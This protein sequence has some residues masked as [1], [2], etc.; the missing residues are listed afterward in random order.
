MKKAIFTLAAVT[1][2]VFW[3]SGCGATFDPSSKINRFRILSVEI[4]KS[5][6]EFG[7]EINLSAL[8]VNE[9]GSVAKSAKY[10]WIISDSSVSLRDPE[11]AGEAFVNFFFS[12]GFAPSAKTTLPTIDK[13]KNA[14][15]A[16]GGQLYL[17]A[18]VTREEIELDKIINMS[19]TEAQAYFMSLL[20]SG[21]TRVALR[22]VYLLPPKPPK[23]VAIPPTPKI[24]KLEAYY[25]NEKLGEI[26][27]VKSPSLEDAAA[28]FEVEVAPKGG[29][30]PEGDR[31][32]VKPGED[33]EFRLEIT[34]A[35]IDETWLDIAWY[36]TKELPFRRKVKNEW[37]AP[38][39]TDKAQKPDDMPVGLPE[40]IKEPNVYPLY[41]ITRYR[42]QT[43]DYGGLFIRV[44][45]AQ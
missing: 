30:C 24:V 34:P 37:A 35:E 12:A 32:C 40:E 43:Q 31:K 25:K 18:L 7:S 26:V 6:A 38:E 14:D 36:C 21:S 42:A 19:E 2:A 27:P 11:L 28:I 17:I 45:A 4:D 29:V 15:P 8:A 39:I 23:P 16:A 1:L 44:K 3:L 5:Y 13:V 41:I 10:V 33:I 22:T 9:D 20:E